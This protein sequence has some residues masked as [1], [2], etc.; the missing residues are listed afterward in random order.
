M[1]EKG[2]IEREREKIE[3]KEGRKVTGKDSE[4]GARH[5]GLK[6]EIRWKVRQKRQIKR[7]EEDLKRRKGGR[8]GTW[9]RVK[10]IERRREIARK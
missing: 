3:E 1:L 4:E 9:R 2:T 10:H 5:R 7:K 8:K 6:R